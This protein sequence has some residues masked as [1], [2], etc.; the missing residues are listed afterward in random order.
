MSWFFNLYQRVQI[1]RTTVSWKK[2]KRKLG[3]NRKTPLWSNWSI[4][5][6]IQALERMK[7]FTLASLWRLPIPEG[8]VRMKLKL[9][10]VFLKHSGDKDSAGTLW[11]QKEFSKEWKDE[12]KAEHQLYKGLF[13]AGVHW[14]LPCS[15]VTRTY[16]FS[17]VLLCTT[18]PRRGGASGTNPSAHLTCWEA[19][20]RQVGMEHW[21]GALSLRGL[22]PR[23]T[24]I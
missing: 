3:Q 24:W 11:R 21:R 2:T 13:S 15:S 20:M 9:R 22:V 18:G 14:K 10:I 4:M 16:S 12:N 17:E 6:W 19:Q 1:T 8:R 23:A 7:R 5:K